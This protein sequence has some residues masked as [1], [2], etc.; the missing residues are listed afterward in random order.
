MIKNQDF[1]ELEE[2]GWIYWTK[3]WDE[4]PYWKIYLSESEGQIT[5]DL[6]G[7]EFWTNQQWS[8]EVESL[9]WKRVFD[10]PKPK[11][12]IQHFITIWTN[13]DSLILDFFA[14]SGTTAHA[15]MELNAQDGGTRK[16][17]SVQ[18][19]ELTDE[20]SEAY[21]AG[22][23]TISQITRERI[24][25]AGEKILEDKKE[26]LT[27]REIPLDIGFKAF[28]LAPSHYRQWQTITED[29]TEAE[30]KAQI[31]LFEKQ[32]LIDDY[33]EIAVVYEILIKE[34]MALLSQ[35]HYETTPNIRRI[36]DDTKSMVIS[37]SKTLTEADIETMKLKKE[38]IFVCPDSALT[39][40]LKLNLER[41]REVRVV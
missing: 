1:I 22:Y 7:I 40:S 27:K 20:K 13:Q 3:W 9:F 26:E 34:W 37:F 17:I 38:D 41:N 24:R 8:L 15:V 14:G 25:R 11:S 16:C 30:L 29:Q 39:D 32:P 6:L 5:S 28:C 21:K 23:T 10:F 19:P 31:A 18:L 33:D 36:Q 2:K 4:Q 12:L 35:I